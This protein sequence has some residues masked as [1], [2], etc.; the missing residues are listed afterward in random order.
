M[1][2]ITTVKISDL[3]QLFNQNS[4][5]LSE[6]KRL[7]EIEEEVKAYTVQQT[8][9]LLNLH[10]CTIRRLVTK[11]KLLCKYLEGNAGKYII[12]YSAIKAYLKS[13]ENSNQ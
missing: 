10:H 2:G 9:D 1:E 13:K 12:P 7:R 4:E 8:A 6:I 5:L 11:R 3:T